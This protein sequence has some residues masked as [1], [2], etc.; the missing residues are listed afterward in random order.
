M[1][2]HQ[3][4]NGLYVR[5]LI[6]DEPEDTLVYIHGL[7]E[8]SLCFERL[9]VHP[10]LRRWNHVMPDL[11]GYG[12]SPWPESPTGLE[13]HARRLADWLREKQ[14][15]P[16]IL[17]G[18]SMGGVIGLILCE[19][20]PEY[21]R[22]YINVEG[23]ISL[24]DCTFSRRAADFPL[25]AF[26]AR[27]FDLMCGEIYRGG[28]TDPAL[29]TY[30]ASMRICDPRMHHLNSS[31]LV[32]LARSGRLAARLAAL[33]IPYIYILGDPRGTGETSRRM[34]TEAGVDWRMIPDA[35][36][37]PFIDQPDGFAGEVAG[38]IN[39]LEKN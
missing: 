16:C 11:P 14:M 21:V 13:A 2:R 8:S 22:A 38:F 30:F 15:P 33:R 3:I 39:H 4:E 10:A 31:E 6:R 28:M 7:G 12:K 1:I 9:A 36:H 17:V 20:F 24:P 26:V 25:D 35:G 5:S 34:L 23:N 29:R 37:W 32:S 19:K 18:H 27:G